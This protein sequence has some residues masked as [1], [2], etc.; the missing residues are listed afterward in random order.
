[1]PGKWKKEYAAM[2][3]PIPALLV[4][5]IVMSSN[6]IGPFVYGQNLI[7]YFILAPFLFFLFAVRQNAPVT[8]VAIK[9]PIAIPMHIAKTGKRLPVILNSR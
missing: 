9:S 3:V 6:E 4:G 7:C 8:T 2:L 5:A 1:M